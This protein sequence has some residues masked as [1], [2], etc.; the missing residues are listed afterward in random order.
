MAICEA[1]QQADSRT[2][3]MAQLSVI[4]GSA[5]TWTGERNPGTAA[6]G[7]GKDALALGPTPLPGSGDAE[8]PPREGGS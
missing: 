5:T 2:R 4:P 7:V 6:A 3:D 8:H 1:E